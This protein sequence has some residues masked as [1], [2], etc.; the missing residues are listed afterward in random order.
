[1]C[2]L[3]DE[4]S[5][6]D[7]EDSR[8]ESANRSSRYWFWIIVLLILLIILLAVPFAV[9][10]VAIKKSGW[11]T[12]HRVAEA[13]TTKVKKLQVTN[14]EVIPDLSSLR[15]TVERAASNALAFSGIEVQ[16]HGLKIQVEPPATLETAANSVHEVLARNHQQFVEAVD[17][18]KIRIIVIL[19][20]S[21][22]THLAQ[23]LEESCAHVGFNY[24]GPSETRTTTNSTDTM[25]AEIEI[26]RKPAK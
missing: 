2:V 19:K 23:L 18:D 20:I 25:V 6:I 21:E 11:E 3:D 26:L 5:M 1:M 12:V 13:A 8:S 16:D 17:P 7:D 22:W 9:V 10:G 15:A 24:R 14:K 4:E